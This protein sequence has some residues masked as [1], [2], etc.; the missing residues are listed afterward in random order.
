MWEIMTK[1]MIQVFALV[2]ANRRARK[3]AHDKMRIAALKAFHTTEAYYERRAAGENNSRDDE[4]EIAQQWAEASI[5]VE[6]F[7]ANLSE[8]LGKK[9]Q[10]WRDGAIWSDEEI[11]SAGIGLDQVRQEAMILKK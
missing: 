1:I 7:D 9:S 11:K 2:P 3:E 4:L 6:P 8:R 5:L 10:F